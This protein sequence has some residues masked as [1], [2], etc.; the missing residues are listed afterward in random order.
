[1]ASATEDQIF[2]T[3]RPLSRKERGEERRGNHR[4]NPPLALRERGHGVRLILPSVA[5]GIAFSRMVGHHPPRLVR[6]DFWTSREA[7][8]GAATATAT[9][10][11]QSVVLGKNLDQFFHHGSGHG[12]CFRS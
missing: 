12:G 5:V 8:G 2:L 7:A 10:E 11:F 4:Q 6:F 9:G 3:P 1:M